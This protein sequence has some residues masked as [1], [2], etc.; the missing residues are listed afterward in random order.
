MFDSLLLLKDYISLKKRPAS[1]R[2]V[3]TYPS[4]DDNQL[5]GFQHITAF[6]V[7]GIDID[8]LGE[9]GLQVQQILSLVENPE[10][11]QPATGVVDLEGSMALR[12][13]FQCY[14]SFSGARED[15][16]ILPHRF[17]IHRCY[18]LAIGVAVAGNETQV[19]T[20]GICCIKGIKARRA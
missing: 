12:E 20:C 16:K 7:D 11:H 9:T 2:A 6:V 15:R 10:E 13:V 17:F 5:R 8:A 18:R 19:C 3:S 4:F 1:V 14:I